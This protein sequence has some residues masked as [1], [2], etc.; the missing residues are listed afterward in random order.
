MKIDKLSELNQT[1]KDVLFGV[2]VGDALG[3][4]VE[5]LDRAYLKANPVSDMIGYGTHQVPAGTFSDD[6]SMSFCL[7]EALTSEL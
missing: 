2:A 3:V 4:P 1:C 6:S 5:F 7:A